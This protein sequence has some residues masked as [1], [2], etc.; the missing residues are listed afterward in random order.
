MSAPHHESSE[1]AEAR[2]RLLDQF[3]NRTEPRFP[4]GKLN[5]RDE[6]EL[7]FA[8]AADKDKGVVILRFG[9]SVDWIGFG[10]REARMLAELLNAKADQLEH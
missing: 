6:G 7:A 10:P 2:S 8:V 9:K 1:E 3:L 4:Q 5:A